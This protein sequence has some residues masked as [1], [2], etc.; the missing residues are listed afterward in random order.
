MARIFG[1]P[2]YYLT[3]WA[4]TVTALA[5]GAIIWTV[6]DRWTA[7]RGSTAATVGDRLAKAA[8]GLA[9]IA[10]VATAVAFADAHHPE[11]RLS[12]A[13]RDAQRTDL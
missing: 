13:V 8:A 7:G 5:A 2:W 9:A 12:D 3:L 6:V 1:R 11:E 4:W 10:T